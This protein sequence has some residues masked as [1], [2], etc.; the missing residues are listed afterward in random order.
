MLVELSSMIGGERR[1]V[2]MEVDRVR[3]S[4][5]EE[6]IAFFSFLQHLR[7]CALMGRNGCYRLTGGKLLDDYEGRPSH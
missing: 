3:Y 4:G 6:P 2:K 1:R 7:G 5:Q